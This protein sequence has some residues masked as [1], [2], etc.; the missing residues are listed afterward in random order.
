MPPN[1]KTKQSLLATFVAA[2]ALPL[3]V[4]STAQPEKV[5][6]DSSVRAGARV[7]SPLER[8][9]PSGSARRVTLLHRLEDGLMENRGVEVL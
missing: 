6:D 8:P 7:C 4:S 3:G 5:T 2:V 1:T 9:A